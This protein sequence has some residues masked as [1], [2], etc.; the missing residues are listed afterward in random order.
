M[1]KQLS[2]LMALVAAMALPSVAGQ[3]KGKGKG[4]EHAPGQH[5]DKHGVG[6]E[7]FARIAHDL[8]LS[9]EQQKKLK[10]VWDDTDAKMKA[11]MEDKS[12]TKDQKHK[13]IQEI[14]DEGEKKFRAL[15]TPDQVKKLEA[16]KKEAEAKAKAHNAKAKAR[17]E[18]RG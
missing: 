15:L 18:K 1:L 8:Q 9:D 13:K 12:L 10:P 11:V 3:A 5:K 4:L 16:M 17:A 7:R 14:H 2:V 6:H